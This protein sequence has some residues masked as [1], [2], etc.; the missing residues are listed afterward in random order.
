[1]IKIFYNLSNDFID[2]PDFEEIRLN[3]DDI[4]KINYKKTNFDG[5]YAKVKNIPLGMLARKEKD[6]SDT[7]SL[8]RKKSVEPS[9]LGDCEERHLE[10]LIGYVYVTVTF[11]PDK[12]VLDKPE[13][14]Q[15]PVCKLIPLNMREQIPFENI[16]AKQI[17]LNKKKIFDKINEFYIKM[18]KLKEIT[19]DEKKIDNISI[20]ETREHLNYFEELNINEE[21]QLDKIDENEDFSYFEVK[22]LYFFKCLTFI[23]FKNTKFN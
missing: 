17:Y 5:F 3:T 2:E 14:I 21:L 19:L 16:L 13:V 22:L 12:T 18:Q 9:L 8:E 4:V 23:M 7:N 20:H 15:I 11:S 6:V 10:D 1:L